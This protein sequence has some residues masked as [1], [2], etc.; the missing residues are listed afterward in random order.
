M[1]RLT[2]VELIKRSVLFGN[3]E[4]ASVKIS[5]DGNHLSFNSI[6]NEACFR[7]IIFNAEDLYEQ[8]KKDDFWD[9]AFEAKFNNWSGSEKIELQIKGLRPSRGAA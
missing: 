3:P 6:E 8:M 4:R 5:P 7:S 2:E 1:D 9:I